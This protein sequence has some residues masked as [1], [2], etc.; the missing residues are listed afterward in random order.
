M[1]HMEIRTERLFASGAS[2]TVFGAHLFH[3][4]CG[5]TLAARSGRAGARRAVYPPVR[6]SRRLGVVVFVVIVTVFGKVLRAMRTR[7]VLQNPPLDRTTI[8]ECR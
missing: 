2:P 1:V 3:G 6:S 4:V 8:S 5:N 7:A